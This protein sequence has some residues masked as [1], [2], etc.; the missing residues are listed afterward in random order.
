MEITRISLTRQEIK[1]IYEATIAFP[2]SQAF[3]IQEESGNGI[4]HSITLTTGEQEVNGITA[5]VI[6]EITGPEDW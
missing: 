3:T 1:K 2:N 6:I 5:K 4:G